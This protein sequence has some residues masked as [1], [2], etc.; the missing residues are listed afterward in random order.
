MGESCQCHKDGKYYSFYTDEESFIPMQVRAPELY[1]THLL[2]KSEFKAMML[3]NVFRQYFDV[4]L[5]DK[6][7]EDYIEFSFYDN[8]MATDGTGIIYHGEGLKPEEVCLVPYLLYD[9]S[10]CKTYTDDEKVSASE[11]AKAVADFTVSFQKLLKAS[12]YY[13]S[14]GIQDL[15]EDGL[16]DISGEPG[17]WQFNNE[18]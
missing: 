2:K 9:E 15:I 1:D 18:D 10:R 7:P 3:Y 4:P 6:Q 5:L 14:N 17:G 16:I 13:E 12:S 8:G 11:F